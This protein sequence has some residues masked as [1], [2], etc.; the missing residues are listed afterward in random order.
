MKK[1]I[2]AL[3]VL[4]F[5]LPALAQEE[6][7]AGDYASSIAGGP[8]DVPPGVYASTA[9]RVADFFGATKG[10]RTIFAERENGVMTLRRG[11]EI[12]SGEKIVI[13]ED[14][15]T[16]GKSTLETAEQIKALGGVVV[17]SIC[18]VD[19]RPADAEEPFPWPL[20]A[21]LRQPA[22]LWDAADCELCKEGKTPAV[23]PASRKVF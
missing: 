4:A 21:A 13:A 7:V 6:D 9:K 11:F 12:K 2:L 1:I 17:A 8:L 10:A 5:A 16:T 3:A 15:V 22:V 19:R 18:I 20:F 23:K 14:V